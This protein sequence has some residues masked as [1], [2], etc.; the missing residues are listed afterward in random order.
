M[1]V[2]ISEPERCTHARPSSRRRVSAKAL[3][4][5]CE[6][7]GSHW[8]Q[9]HPVEMTVLRCRMIHTPSAISGLRVISPMRWPVSNAMRSKSRTP[10]LIGFA[11]VRPFQK[12]PTSSS[13]STRSRDFSTPRRERF[14]AGFCSTSPSRIAQL[15][16]QRRQATNLL[17]AM[18]EPRSATRSSSAAMSLRVTSVC[19]STAL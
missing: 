3:L 17:D 15:N 18:G 9:R 12:R 19:L 10:S 16:M 7:L 5:P 1:D 14:C 11:V 8:Q 4:A 6:D 2:E 13:L